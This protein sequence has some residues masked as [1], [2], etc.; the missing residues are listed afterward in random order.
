MLRFLETTE[1]S[2][3]VRSE[4]SNY[5]RG[6]KVKNGSGKKV[7]NSSG[8]KSKIVKNLVPIHN[9]NESRGDTW[10]KVIASG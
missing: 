5:N 7:K 9:S 3:K 10:Q 2:R 8:K 4:E 1:N 6:K